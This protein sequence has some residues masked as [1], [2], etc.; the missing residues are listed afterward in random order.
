M[1][2]F[3]R[4]AQLP[5][6][7]SSIAR[8]NSFGN[9]AHMSAS[10]NDFVLRVNAGGI[11]GIKENQHIA[12]G[13]FNLLGKYGINVVP[14]NYLIASETLVEGVKQPRLL[15]IANFV[16]GDSLVQP[17]GASSEQ[18]T[19]LLNGLFSYYQDKVRT[20]ETCLSDIDRLS[21]F[22][23]GS[24]KG[25]EKKIY[26]VDLDLYLR[27]STNLAF[28]FRNLRIMKYYMTRYDYCLPTDWQ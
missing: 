20:K 3:E 1:M 25:G 28:V 16:E 19:D 12:E 15:T 18:V 24:I 27:D 22:V 7:G 13:E 10:G 17:T 14:H 23:Y 5:I 4:W 6:R 8:L 11:N 21:Q 26:L 2:E 9:L